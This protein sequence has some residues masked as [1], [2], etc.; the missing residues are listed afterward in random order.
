MASQDIQL[1]KVQ[2]D[3][4]N[5]TDKVKYAVQKGPAQFTANT[6][7]AIS[8]TPSS[9]VYNVVIPS[10]STVID[11]RVLWKS[12]C[13]IRVDCTGVP[14]GQ[15]PCNYGLTDALGPM[16]LHSLCTTIQSTINNTTVSVNINDL[17]APLLKIHDS[18]ELNAYNSMS[19][20]LSD[21]YK[22]YSDAL[23]SN[24][25]PLGSY[26]NIADEDII[27]RGAFSDVIIGANWTAGSAPSGALSNTGGAQTF[28][29][30]FTVTEPIFG[31]SPWTWAKCQS[32]NQGIYG[33]N[34]LTFQMQMNPTS[35]RVFRSANNYNQI[36]AVQEFRDSELFLNYL[37]MQPSQL[38]SARN[39]VPYME[40]PR[41]LSTYNNPVLPGA[42]AVISSQSI[43][44]Q[45]IPDS[46]LIFVRRQL[47]QMT[48]STSDYF[49]PIKN[50]SIQ[51][52]NQSG[53][54][55]SMSQQ[56]LYQLS[57]KNG[58]N[59]TWSQFKGSANN[60][61][62]ATGVGSAIPLCGSVLWL[63]F[64]SDIAQNQDYFAPGSLGQ[65][66]IQVNAT[67]Q[68]NN[69]GPGPIGTEFNLELVMVPINSGVFVTERGQSSVYTGLLTREDV[70]NTSSQ[71][72]YTR[73]DVKRMVGGGFLDGL[74]SV[75]G[76]VGSVVSNPKVQELAKCGLKAA[77]GNGRSG[78]A[79]MSKRL[80]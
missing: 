42:E 58:L 50:I 44:L 53:I 78:G 71:E 43:Q 35:S 38:V 11:R 17:L 36:V 72:G 65:F 63:N 8:A 75:M 48:P 64:F 77:L 56:G 18:R 19:P 76:K 67:V 68:N 16:P 25:N 59:M 46:M 37:T 33:I 22:N 21:N 80:M 39:V 13:V 49:L 15:L 40:F 79:D 24:N 5:V 61:N 30:Q 6:Y 28:Y 12:T 69:P 57:R 60:S 1:V 73:S 51:F 3:T 70:L 52:N 23:N 54:L 74:R 45:Q 32:N 55:A 10:E 7:K 31:L 41:F 4:L 14:V 29:V 62:T 34:N 47:G 9:H 20:T 2:D 66:N 26:Q 27:P